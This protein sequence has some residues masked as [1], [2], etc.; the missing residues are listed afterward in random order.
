M[1]K[2]Y[3][4]VWVDLTIGEIVYSMLRLAH[5]TSAASQN[6]IPEFE[7]RFASFIGT[8]HAVAFANCRSALYYSL[9]A[10]DFEPGSEVIIPA[11]TFWIDPA[12]TVLAGLTP[13]FVDVQLDSLNI[14]PDKIEAAITPKTR[15]IL[16]PHLN[17]LAMDMDP[18]MAI[19]EKHGLRVI[20]DSARICGGRYKGRRV[21]SFDI[22]AFSF[23]YGKSFYG[24]GGGMLT[25]DDSDFIARVRELQAKEFHD[26]STKNLFA[27]IIK[28]CLLKFLNTPILH[29]I[30][31]FQAVKRYELRPE[32]Q[33]VSWFRVNKTPMTEIPEM[34]TRRM[35]S[36]Q[37]KIGF[38][39]LET[40]DESN[41]I[42]RN[43]LAYYNQALADIP[44]L[45]LPIDP[46]DREHVCVHYVVWSEDKRKMQE[47]LLSQNIDAQDESAQDVTQM[48][49]FKGF[50]KGPYPNAAILNDRLCYIPAHPCLDEGD[51]QY[52]SGRIRA[53]FDGAATN[54][55]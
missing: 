14:D 20:E 17:G 4:R 51:L 55:S 21:G 8:K 26:I 10:L 53:F 36:I 16:A 18:I 13:V 22:G 54:Q 15:A 48:E 41:K 24:F 1:I 39:Q 35:F 40:I 42:R 52:I 38:R 9:K 27:A 34:F 44:G 37:A 5:P 33:F 45:R 28:G 12:V 25:S 7:Q 29:G 30:S 23:G 49:Q 47:Y 46:D 11:F 2:A 50:A 19:A 6:N 32:P 31:L 43:S 3:P